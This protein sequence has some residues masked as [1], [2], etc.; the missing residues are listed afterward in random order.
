MD[1]TVK[2]RIMSKD[3]DPSSSAPVCKPGDFKMRLN[4]QTANQICGISGSK[5]PQLSQQVS[6]FN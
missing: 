4:T 5:Q 6:G 2:K 3:Y 1:N